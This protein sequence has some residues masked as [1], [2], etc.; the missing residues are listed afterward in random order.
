[1]SPQGR[2]PIIDCDGHVLEPIDIWDRWVEGK[3]RERAK[4]A[5]QV[6]NLPGGGSRLRLNGELFPHRTMHSAGTFGIPHDRVAGLGWRPE[7]LCRGGFDPHARIRDQ[8][9]PGG[10]EAALLFGSM[11]NQ[12][13]G[14]KDG[15]ILAIM[16]R[17]YNRW[18]SEEYA[19]AYPDRLFPIAIV[20][21]HDAPR[22]REE[23]VWAAE[24]GFLGVKLPAKRLLHD[25]P[26]Y[27]DEFMPLWETAEEAG[28]VI[29]V[30]PSS[31]DYLPSMA[32]VLLREQHSL[33]TA[34]AIVSPLNGL[35]TLTHF[36]YGGVL[37]RCPA[38]KVCVVECHGGWL[39]FLLDRLDGRYKFAPHD[40]PHLKGLPSETFRRQ[41]FVAFM[42][43]ERTTLPLFAEAFQDHIV[44]GS[45]YPHLD[46]EDPS[47]IWEVLAP[48]PQA[49]RR[50]I[51]REN[52]ARLYRLPLE[53][54][55]AGRTA[56]AAG[57]R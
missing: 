20:P 22:A 46:A 5:C 41:C 25:R 54:R 44:W 3:H 38:L 32:D 56:R 8:M 11:G 10:I 12:I 30:H 7:D 34:S 18:L 47:E 16:C 55:A 28:L 13:N 6:V 15:E 21:W 19:A 52:A 29:G 33:P 43:E 45:D 26:V 51:L 23:L 39:P 57:G 40:F 50:K 17:G 48:V 31:V 36:I 2:F 37:E 14:V 1:M 9:D 49:V 24:R 53:T 4:E 27:H 42:A 35:T